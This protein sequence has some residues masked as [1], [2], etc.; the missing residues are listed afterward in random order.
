M[1]FVE[2]FHPEL[3]ENPLCQIRKACLFV[4]FEFLSKCSI[5]GE[6]WVTHGWEAKTTS[7]GKECGLFA[8]PHTPYFVIMPYSNK[9]SFS[10][11]SYRRFFI[12]PTSVHVT[13]VALWLLCDACLWLALYYECP[14]VCLEYLAW[15]FKFRY[16]FN[17]ILLYEKLS[18]GNVGLTYG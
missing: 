12:W 1:Y 3:G 18:L 13:Y 16:A 15:L 4:P 5:R 8:S 2:K 7:L 11:T 17:S 14:Y 10:P 9:R 6:W